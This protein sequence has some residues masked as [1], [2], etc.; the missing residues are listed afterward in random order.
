MSKEGC[1]SSGLSP[2]AT[3]AEQMAYWMREYGSRIPEIPPDLER[4]CPRCEAINPCT[5]AYTCLQC[6]HSLKRAK[7]VRGAPQHNP[8]IIDTSAQSCH[9]FRQMGRYMQISCYIMKSQ[10]HMLQVR[11]FL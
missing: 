4:V 11:T 8:N 3:P 2:N 9:L 10:H 5:S 6:G 7:R 1:P